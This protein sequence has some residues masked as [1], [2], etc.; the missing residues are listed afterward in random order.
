VF[1]HAATRGILINSSINP[2]V[3]GKLSY[4]LFQIINDR[5]SI[6]ALFNVRFPQCI[7]KDIKSIEKDNS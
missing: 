6:A 5:L 1:S 3:L 4:S 2:L 7:G